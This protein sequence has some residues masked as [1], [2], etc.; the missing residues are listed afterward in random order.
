M[1]KRKM[2]KFVKENWLLVAAILY[3]LSPI[4]LIPDFVPAIGYSDDLAILVLTLIINYLRFRK[5][6]KNNVIEGEVVE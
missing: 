2:M 4:D 1:N 3:V 6:V 5:K